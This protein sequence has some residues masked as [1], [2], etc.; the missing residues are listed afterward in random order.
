MRVWIAAIMAAAL[1]AQA[2][3]AQHKSP[4]PGPTDKEKAAAQAKRNFEKDNDE[5]Y[6]SSLSKIP[7]A[8]KADPWGSLRTP[9]GSTGGK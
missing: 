5:A 6:K 9:G 3:N 4:G 7:D 2:A 8:K 1:F